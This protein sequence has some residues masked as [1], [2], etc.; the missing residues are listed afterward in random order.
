M[1]LIWCDLAH[2]LRGRSGAQRR[3]V[4]KAH[5]RQREQ[6][7]RIGAELIE[8]PTARVENEKADERDRIGKCGAAEERHE[9]IAAHRQDASSLELRCTRTR[10]ERRAAPQQVRQAREGLL[11]QVRDGE[12]VRQQEVAIHLNEW[13][14]IEQAPDAANRHDHEQGS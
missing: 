6:R 4:Q 9:P 13:I 14:E 8:D 11:S 7:Q 1:R 5:E 12:I 2:I 10:F 3:F